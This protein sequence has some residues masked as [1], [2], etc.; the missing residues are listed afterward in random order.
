[1]EKENPTSGVVLYH[2]KGK[3]GL[4]NHEGKIINNFELSKG[5]A[6]AIYDY[7]NFGAFNGMFD[8]LSLKN[9]IDALAVHY[10]YL[11]AETQNRELRSFLNKEFEH[12]SEMLNQFYNEQTKDE[13]QPM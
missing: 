1:M 9:Y 3:Y 2:L 8:I 7:L 13:N 10:D 5:Q 6:Q 4:S 11:I 12:K